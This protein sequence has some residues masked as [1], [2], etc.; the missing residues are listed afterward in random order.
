MKNTHTND[1][2]HYYDELTKPVAQLHRTTGVDYKI[3]YL[4][5][6]QTLT[7]NFGCT[8]ES[9]LHGQHNV[10]TSAAGTLK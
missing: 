5:K 10:I 2:R 4:Y 7:E 1:K 6:D 8:S 3:K 9:S